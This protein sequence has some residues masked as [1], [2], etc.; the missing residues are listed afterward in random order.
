KQLALEK[1]KAKGSPAV[2]TPT[3]LS[4]YELSK[5]RKRVVDQVSQAEDA[6]HKLE[7]RLKE[8]E[9]ALATPTVTDDVMRLSKEHGEVQ[10]AIHNALEAWEKVVSYAHSL[11]V[12][13]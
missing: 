2:T 1:K 7:E 4:A 8:I 9:T 10:I 11:G 3:K 12:E 5:E 6:V 13:V